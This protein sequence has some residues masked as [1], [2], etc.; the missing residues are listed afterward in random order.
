MSRHDPIV[1]QAIRNVL[2]RQS[3]SDWARV[4]GSSIVNAIYDEV[5]RLDLAA[6]RSTRPSSE[7]AADVMIDDTAPALHGSN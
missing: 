5:R 7:D 3:L 2:G 4:S 1:I 6:A